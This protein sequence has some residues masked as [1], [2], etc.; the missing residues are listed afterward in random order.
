VQGELRRHL[1][2]YRSQWEA[3]ARLDALWAVLTLDDKLGDGWNERAFFETGRQEIDEVFDFMARNRIASPPLQQ[4]L[5]FGCGVGRLT[6]PLAARARHVVGVDISEEMIRLAR[7][8]FPHI[9]FHLNEK[10]DLSDFES[11]SVDFIYTNIVLQ[12][13]DDGLQRHYI[14]EFA[15][16]LRP[17]GL[18]VFQIP[19]REPGLPRTVRT[20]RMLASLRPRGVIGL[21]GKAFRERLAPW[22]AR[23]ELNVLPKTEVIDV[24]RSCGLRLEAIGNI[25]W[26]AFYTRNHFQLE[27]EANE[28]DDQ[29]EFPLSHLYFFRKGSSV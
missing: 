23:M 18:A 4:V 16:L 29:S 20:L 25:N 8:Y 10:D 24:A 13:L 15:R 22:R 12:H 7:K 19:G 27:P 14:R 9:A 2:R 1:Q 3:N 11:G 21:L 26:K 17:E 6:E 28:L 5:D